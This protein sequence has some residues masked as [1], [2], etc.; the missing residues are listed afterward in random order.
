MPQLHD[1]LFLQVYSDPVHAEGGDLRGL[2]VQALARGS[3]WQQLGLQPG[4]LLTAFNGRPLDS[5]VAWQHWLDVAQNERTV[6][7]TL[8]REAERLRYRTRTVQ[9]R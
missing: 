4:D 6:L 3:F 5:M 1:A 2:R 7:I 8:E 9:P